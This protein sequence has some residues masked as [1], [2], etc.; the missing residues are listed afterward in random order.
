[1]R[2]GGEARNG[3]RAGRSG[4]SPHAVRPQDVVRWGP[5]WGRRVGQFLDHVVWRTTVTGAENVPKSGPVILA[6]NHTGVIDGPILHGASPRGSHI[7][8]KSEMFTGVLGWILTHSGQVPVDRRNGRAALKAALALLAEG[9]VVGIFPEGTRGT[10]A[11]ASA[12][13]GVAFLA[14]HSGAPVVPVAILG[15]RP[16]GK[17]VGHVPRPRRRLHVVFGEPF[18]AVE[19]DVG[20]G[21]QALQAAM[22]RIQER[23]SRHVDAAAGETG[24]GLPEEVA[25]VTAEE[26]T[27][28]EDGGMSHEDEAGAAGHEIVVTRRLSAP[29]EAVWAVLT[30][31]EHAPET[32]RAVTKVELLTPGPY[33]VG[34]RW[35]ETRQM[36]GREAT[37]E[38]WVTASEAPSRT[39]VEANP[40]KTR[41][42]TTFTLRPAGSG[43]QLDVR[44]TARTLRPKPWERVLWKL[45]GPLGARATRKVL[46][47]DLEDIA[48][49]TR[50]RAEPA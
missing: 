39:V 29:P 49:A 46:Q 12:Q 20:S 6:A 37:E 45:F 24:V 47:K 34:T 16:T 44:F 30:D 11:V 32:L 22:E 28:G 15:T 50:T 41:Y 18:A 13:A 27:S 43:T 38:I 26:A 42:T 33:G 9:R 1:M 5:V 7:I 21:R 19:G 17:G 10:G 48:E 35:R 3:G 2:T 4:R 36:W 40:G 8:V 14:V 31:L 25:N 23:L